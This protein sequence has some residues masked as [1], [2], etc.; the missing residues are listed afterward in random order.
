MRYPE[1]FL[2][3]LIDSFRRGSNGNRNFS[4]QSVIP[5]HTMASKIRAENM[6]NQKSGLP[7]DPR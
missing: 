2:A 1:I 3:E 4:I 7:K 5:N 6:L